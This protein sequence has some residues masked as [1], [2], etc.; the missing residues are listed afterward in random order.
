[1]SVWLSL[2]H[3]LTFAYLSAAW[4]ILY[5]ETRE[6]WILYLQLTGLVT[7]GVSGIIDDL[8]VL[9]VAA[10]GYAAVTFIGLVL[11]GLIDAFVPNRGRERLCSSLC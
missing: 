8:G 3:D 5:A 1:V 6:R 11:G 9:A 2:P 7:W 4:W 10:G